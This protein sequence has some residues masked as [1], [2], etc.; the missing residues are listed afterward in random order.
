M[1]QMSETSIDFF[2]V[3]VSGNFLISPT[4]WYENIENQ[5]SNMNIEQII[6]VKSP[7]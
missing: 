1:T 5:P 6:R 4:Q 3:K 2:P 7:M